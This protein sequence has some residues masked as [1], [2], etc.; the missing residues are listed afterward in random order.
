MH[1]TYIGPI[2]EGSEGGKSGRRG[3]RDMRRGCEGLL[4]G[5]GLTMSCIM[6]VLGTRGN[7]VYRYIVCV[8]EHELCVRDTRP[9]GVCLLC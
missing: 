6:C 8:R 1:I 9:R 4:A 5:G 7:K 2:S 3:G